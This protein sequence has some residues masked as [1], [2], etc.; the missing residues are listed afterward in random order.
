MTGHVD[1]TPPL[2][3]CSTSGA[4]PFAPCSWPVEGFL[5]LP[6]TFF[7]F[8]SGLQLPGLHQTTGHFRES[9]CVAPCS[10]AKR[11]TGGVRTGRVH[12]VGKS[13]PAVGPQLSST[14]IQPWFVCQ[15][16]V[17]GIY[18]CVYSGL[19]DR[20]ERRVPYIYRS[21][22]FKEERG[23]FDRTENLEFVPTSGP[24]GQQGCGLGTYLECLTLLTNTC[25]GGH[26]ATLW[27]VPQP[28]QPSVAR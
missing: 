11:P 4:A 27:P 24:F 21:G 14:T 12:A 6:S 28:N 3:P 5:L 23:I 2:L 17:L 18:L 22:L 1:P 15:R 19:Q 26:R 16:G 25:G 8:Q 7:P 20:N 9:R 13:C 10:H